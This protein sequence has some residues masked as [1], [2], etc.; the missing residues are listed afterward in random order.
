[1]QHIFHHNSS[2]N[3]A[4]TNELLSKEVLRAIS[5]HPVKKYEYQYR[6]HNFLNYRKI[7]DLRQRYL[8]LKREV[9]KLRND[10]ANSSAS[11]LKTTTT[12]RQEDNFEVESEFENLAFD[13]NENLSCHL[14]KNRFYLAPSL[15][16]V[17]NLS[18][19]E[20]RHDFDFFTRSLFASS[21]ISPKRGLEGY[22]KKILNDNIRQI[23]DEINENS[24]ERGRL[25]DFKDILYGYMR[26][27]PLYGID[28]VLD[29]LLV[30]RKYEGR[31][32][33]VPVRRHAYVRNTYSG[34]MFREDNFD[35]SIYFQLPEKY[36][37]GTNRPSE[38]D[39]SH[40]F[41][42]NKNLVKR[43]AGLVIPDMVKNLFAPSKTSSDNEPTQANKSLIIDANLVSINFT[44][45][46]SFYTNKI[47]QDKRIHFVLPLT[48]RWQIFTRFMKNYED[49]CLKRRENAMLV[50]VLFQS[51]ET[52]LIL[53]EKSGLLMKQSDKIEQLFQHLNQK[54]SLDDQ[55]KLVVKGNKFSRSIGC[56]IGAAL[57]DPRQLIFF[58]DV[59]I[60][61]TS[62]F[63][64]RARLN[65]IEF[66]QVYY[67]IVFSEYDPDEPGEAIKILDSGADS[68]AQSSRVRENHLDLNMDTGYW[69]Q[70]GFGIV[71]VYNSD[72][73]RV[74]GFDTSIVGWGKEDVDLYEKF[75][76][77]NMTIFRSVDPGLIHV[78]HKIECDPSLAEEQMIMCL[79]SKSTS[80]ASQRKLAQ[81]VF[82]KRAYMKVSRVENF[83]NLSVLKKINQEAKVK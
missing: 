26:H 76:K 77:S 43:L 67:P 8:E 29:I 61:F 79:G 3:N 71:A 32:M 50:V 16:T 82:E 5:L 54:Y 13:K 56:E 51:E 10:M 35:S 19:R 78:F 58:V 18:K 30:Y 44:Q 48:G 53:D 75:V 24:I 21:Y 38:A 57:F 81:L 34:L 23:M 68:S 66:K 45:T 39:K 27:H 31:K 2:G 69:R 60:H 46:N 64:L 47:V 74:G 52:K 65:T 6:L 59:D 22:W 15:K 17:E 37:S 4:Y 9:F 12:T 83:F 41:G 20:H 36:R 63:L 7:V 1:M 14:T 25:I 55:L 80:I 42:E 73:R 33:T 70:F 40:F 11:T 28:F 72:L 49:V 62:D